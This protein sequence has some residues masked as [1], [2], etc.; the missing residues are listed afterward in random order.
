MQES[1]DSAEVT[2]NTYAL[3]IYFKMF[4]SH[5]EA[6]LS[7]MSS[8]IYVFFN[9]HSNRRRETP[10]RSPSTI[11]VQLGRLFGRLMLQTI[12]FVHT[13]PH[14]RKFITS[15]FTPEL[16]SIPSLFSSV[17]E[18]RDCLNGCMC[19]LYH[20]QITSQFVGLENNSP[21]SSTNSASQSN[22]LDE[23]LLAFK[24][25]MAEQLGKLSPREKNAAILLEIQQTTG[26]I[27]AAATAFDQE[28]IFD[29]FE[30]AFRGLLLLQ[31]SS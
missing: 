17:E 7:H 5:N 28:T 4:Q 21:E 8:G 29:S 14:E 25:F 13:K 18:A 9:W 12:L 11:D 31:L 16:P 6:A 30:E 10:Q 3:F 2:L 23:W 15:S 19:S 24:S 20:V 22:P 1:N 26:S 27:L